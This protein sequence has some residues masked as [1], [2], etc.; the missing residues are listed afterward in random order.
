M[1]LGV[2][3]GC[4]CH[5]TAS[6]ADEAKT[7]AGY[8]SIGTEV[9]LRM[10]KMI[11]APLVFA[12]L[13]SGVASMDD[14]KS[15]GRVGLK[16]LLWFVAA[17]LV[18]LSIGLLSVNVMHPGANVDLPLPRTGAITNLQTTELNVKEF[19]TRIFPK[20]I[21]DAM[22][23]NE[24]VQILIF[25]LFF[26]VALRK[27]TGDSGRVVRQAVDGL[28]DVMLRIT[29]I[30]MLFAP[31]GI[32]AALAAVITAQGIGVLLTYGKLIGSFY[33]TLALLWAALVFAGYVVLKR[34][35]FGLIRLVREPMMIAFSTAS[36][37]AAYP[38]MIECLQRFGIKKGLVGFVLPLG[39]SFNLDGS[40]VYQAFAAVFIA[41]AFDVQMTLGHQLT[42]L[43]VIMISSKGVAG[44][45][46][47]SL[48]VLAALLPMFGLPEAGL[49]L[50]MGVDQFLD[51]GRTATNVLGNSIATAVVAKWES[52]LGVDS[53]LPRGEATVGTNKQ[54]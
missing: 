24:V 47:G 53:V 26:G 1:V 38:K 49:L 22:A 31:L 29:N 37:E 46:R 15:I 8:F 3:V 2:I 34:R 17:S 12:T 20:S 4:L 27:V 6:D 36:S 23:S 52:Q 9:F 18:S 35:I 44:V 54:S 19:V 40:M 42:M 7:I 5:L 21:F 28:L 48:V 45:P 43:L 51:M 14:T 11:I 32:F 16:A 41:Q 33:V 10:I 30:V 50:V 13:V 25:S 39:Y